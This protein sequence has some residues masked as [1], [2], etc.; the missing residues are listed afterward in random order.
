ML[1]DGGISR[2]P[3]FFLVARIDGKIVG[4]ASIHPRTDKRSH[5][6]EFGVFIRDAYRDLRLGTT[7]TNT[8]TEIQ[9]NV[10]SRFFRFPCTPQIRELFTST[11]N[12][13]IENVADSPE[14]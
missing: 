4:G 5:V 6:E 2:I 8:F 12:V 7:L 14:I 10:V 13:D 9:G 1:N 11:R 3:L